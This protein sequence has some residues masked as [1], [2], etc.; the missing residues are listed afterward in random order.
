MSSLRRSNNFSSAE[1]LKAQQSQIV[2][3]ERK[4]SQRQSLR[5]VVLKRNY[6][7]SLI[8]EKARRSSQTFSINL[9][10]S[11]L[12]SFS[13]S[14]ASPIKQKPQQS[15]KVTRSSTSRKLF[16][17]DENINKSSSSSLPPQDSSSEYL[18]RTKSSPA[19]ME[20][21]P[22]KQSR[23]EEIQEKLKSKWE[24]ITKLE[25]DF[26]YEKERRQKLLREEE[27]KEK[28]RVQMNARAMVRRSLTDGHGIEIRK[29]VG[30]KRRLM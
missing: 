10:N 8:Q 28:R 29:D 4:R 7:I 16:G 27:E 25:R 18:S 19:V 17:S 23:F 13:S 30:A 14:C 15:S 2:P 11:P 9:S 26:I 24:Y 6:R 3:Q 5:I 20:S 21:P 1:Q 22:R 12:V